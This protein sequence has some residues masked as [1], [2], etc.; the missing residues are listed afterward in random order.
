MKQ[1]GYSIRVIKCEDLRM[2]DMYSIFACM[3]FVACKQQSSWQGGY[4]CAMFLRGVEMH[5]DVRR[6]I[7]VPIALI[8]DLRCEVRSTTSGKQIVIRIVSHELL[9]PG[10]QLLI[11]WCI[12]LICCIRPR[13]WMCV[14]PSIEKIQRMYRCPRDWGLSSSWQSN[15]GSP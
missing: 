3:H 6:P 8:A 5:T 14:P 9:D 15:S 2:K 4:I 12:L 7:V 13:L 1:F 10:L 11:C